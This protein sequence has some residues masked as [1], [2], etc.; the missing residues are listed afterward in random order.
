MRIAKRIAHSGHCSRREAERLIAAGRVKLNGQRLASPACTVGEHDEIEIDGQPLSAPQPV[1]LWRY[2]KPRGRLVSNFDPQGRP[3][4]FDTLPEGLPRLITVGR[5]DFNS[6]GLLLLTTSGGL[7]RHLELPSTGW[8]RRYRVRAVG[9]ISPPRL[10]RLQDGIEIEGVRYGPVKARLE[11]EGRNV[12]LS[13]S[14][15]E[16]KNREIRR[17]LEHL[18]LKVSRLIRISY[19]P[20]QLGELASGKLDEIRPRTIAQQIGPAMSASLG[21]PELSCT[22]L[23]GRPA[24]AK[25][26]TRKRTPPRKGGK[27]SRRQ[28]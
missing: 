19:G 20:F 27:P 8:S 23:A 9:R 14:L 28:S 1:R 25:A 17:I 10:D 13:M 16:G 3:T 4:I 11:H 2:H 15:K 7:A 18:G 6:E 26:K 21:L 24:P 22:S 5:L 12:W